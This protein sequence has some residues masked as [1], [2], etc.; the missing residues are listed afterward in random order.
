MSLTRP[1]SK[2]PW[3]ARLAS[4]LPASTEKSSVPSWGRAAWRFLLQIAFRRACGSPCASGSLFR[5]IGL[6]SVA[7]GE[8]EAG[9]AAEQIALLRR[10]LALELGGVDALLALFRRQVAQAANGPVDRL[11]ALRRQLLELLKESARLILLVRSQ[12]LPGF[13]AV[14]DLLLLLAR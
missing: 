6:E 3:L 9:G 12:V 8:R 4:R 2:G 1:G 13:H 7:W 14:E 10:E 5:W 11:A